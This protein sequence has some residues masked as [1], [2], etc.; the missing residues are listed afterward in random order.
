MQADVRQLKGFWR[1]SVGA[2]WHDAIQQ[3]GHSIVVHDT[4]YGALIQYWFKTKEEAEEKIDEVKE[5][6]LQMIEKWI[7]YDRE[8]WDWFT[9]R[10]GW[11][12]QRWPSFEQPYKV[13]EDD[14]GRI[15]YYG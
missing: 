12:V 2:N 3:L 9:I 15:V 7:K 4:Y 8:E 11:G 6:V 10:L 13:I 5:E 1:L 14:K